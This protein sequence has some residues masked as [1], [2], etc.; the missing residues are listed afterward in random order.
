L[1]KPYKTY[2]RYALELKSY[3]PTLSYL[4]QLYAY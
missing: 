2:F 4:C 1:I 3:S